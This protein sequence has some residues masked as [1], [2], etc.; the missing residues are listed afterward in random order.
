MAPPYQPAID[1]QGNADCQNGQDGF[2]N[3]R[4]IEDFVRKNGAAGNGDPNDIVTGK[5][6]D[7]T[8]AG[9]NSVVGKSNYPGL[10]GGTYK[11]RE[12]GIDNLKDVP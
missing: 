3:F 2:P 10:A 8:A 9:A 5:L 1:A 6:S 12:L 4:L 7:G 11:S